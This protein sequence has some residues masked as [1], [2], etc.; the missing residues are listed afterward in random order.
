[1]IIKTNDELLEIVE[2]FNSVKK[3]S[4]KLYKK[5]KIFLE[6]NN[7]IKKIEIN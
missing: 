7:E 4:P 3:E 2:L 6:V 1:M 5:I